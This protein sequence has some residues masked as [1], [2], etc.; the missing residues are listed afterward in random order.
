MGL[1]PRLDIGEKVD[2][3]HC[4]LK[5]VKDLLSN[6]DTKLEALCRAFL[7]RLPH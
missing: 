7:P 4:D 6:I 5:E 1:L 3:A 2:E